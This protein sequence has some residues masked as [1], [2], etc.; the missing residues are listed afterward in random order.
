MNQDSVNDLSSQT[1]LQPRPRG[2]SLNH[3]AMPNSSVWIDL[4][5]ES[6]DEVAECIDLE[7]VGVAGEITTEGTLVKVCPFPLELDD[8]IPV[9]SS[10]G[11]GSTGAGSSKGLLIAANGWMCGGLR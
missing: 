11:F 2:M 5:S 9:G 10:N 3:M 6:T 1:L 4:L 7:A 8:P